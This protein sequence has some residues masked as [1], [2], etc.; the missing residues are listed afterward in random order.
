[1]AVFALLLSIL[2]A[3]L[4]NGQAQS[5][6]TFLGDN[7]A[8]VSVDAEPGSHVYRLIA[9]PS[10]STF[11]IDSVNPANYTSLFNLDT[12]V[13]L[14]YNAETYPQSQNLFV[15]TVQAT[16]ELIN[17]SSFQIITVIV[18]PSSETNPLFPFTQYD[19]STAENQ[20]LG[21]VIQYLQ[22]FSLSPTISQNYSITN[23]PFVFIIDEGTGLVTLNGSLDY[24]TDDYYSLN[25][26]YTDD[27]GIAMTVL[28]IYVSDVNDN[29]P[30]F[31]FYEY[32]FFVKEN[33][34]IGTVIGIVTATDADSLKFGVVEYSFFYSEELFSINPSSGSISTTFFLDYEQDTMYSLSVFAC[35]GGLNPSLCRLIT[36][37]IIVLDVNDNA[38]IFT[39]QTYYMYIYENVPPGTFVGVVSATDVD[40]GMNAQIQYTIVSEMFWINQNGSISTTSLLDYEQDAVFYSLIVQA[41]DGGLEPLC[42]SAT[43]NITVLDE[44]D[45]APIFTQ[46]TYYMS[47]SENIAPGTFVGVVSAT[48]ADDYP[49]NVIIYELLIEGS[50]FSLTMSDGKI[51]TN[52]VLDYES[53]NLY[54]L[55][56]V[57]H[58]MDEIPMS[59]IS[60]VLISVVDVSVDC[61]VFLQSEY[62]EV[63]IYDTKDPPG[64]DHHILTIEASESSDNL[65]YT[66]DITDESVINDP[67][68][69]I[70]ATSGY[71]SLARNDMSIIGNYMLEAKTG[72]NCS[73]STIVQISIGKM[74]CSLHCAIN[75]IILSFYFASCTYLS[76]KCDGWFGLE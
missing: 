33:I 5:Y 43:V 10:N 3:I 14:I 36:A 41:C 29:G 49:N 8:Y 74:M 48:D 42:S 76:C 56:V 24:E 26:I 73:T 38:P 44:N 25:I 21:T 50:A 1:M 22:A 46:H 58:D 53:Q 15:V 2:F 62:D 69:A 63:V 34:A 64:V 30:V 35:D 61:P 12:D 67:V 31:E 75:L 4:R 37:S 68:F 52:S 23:N 19:F 70:N 51:Y 11:T 54:E 47:I 39:Q 60:S 45:N 72:P 28:D 65:F 57:A 55:T 40:S 27:S 16:N 71:I 9:L 59:S 6:I 32:I 66:L 7:V 18:L 17:A 13:D 20:A